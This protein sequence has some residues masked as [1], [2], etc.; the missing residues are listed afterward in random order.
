MAAVM[1][2]G[3]STPRGSS[4][5]AFPYGATIKHS[6]AHS[7]A[8]L[9]PNSYSSVEWEAMRAT[10]T[11]LYAKERQPLA[12]VLRQLRGMGFLVKYVSSTTS[13]VLPLPASSI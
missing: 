11:Q 12:E 8:N 6:A 2:Q 9:T 5:R 13:P 10:I 1:A 7:K 4:M 3:P